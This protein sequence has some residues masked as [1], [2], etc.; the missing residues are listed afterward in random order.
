MNKE[1]RFEA[2]VY[3]NLF[4]T[5]CITLGGFF[6]IVFLPYF[7]FTSFFSGNDFFGSNLSK[8]L[9]SYSLFVT[10]F[11]FLYIYIMVRIFNKKVLV[12]LSKELLKININSKD[13]FLEKLDNIN[14]VKVERRENV[15]GNVAFIVIV[16]TKDNTFHLKSKLKGRSAKE[17]K[18]FYD[19]L[20]EIYSDKTHIKRREVINNKR[21]FVEAYE[22]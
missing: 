10:P 19:T 5:F 14:L 20:K 22:N 15:K 12:S 2:F 4:L 13:V 21:R 9:S 3:R 6:V 1:F 18:D 11:I 7:W 17:F 16:K 8:T